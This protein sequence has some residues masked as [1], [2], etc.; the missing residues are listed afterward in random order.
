MTVQRTT[1]IALLLLVGLSGQPRAQET[2]VGETITTAE[3]TARSVE[4]AC[5]D[6]QVVGVCIWLTCTPYT[7][8]DID[9]SV[10]VFHYLPD[11]TVSS[12]ADSGENPWVDVAA[13]SQPVIELMDG[14]NNTEGSTVINETALRFKNV[15]VFGNPGIEAVSEALESTEYFCESEATMM[16]PYFLSVY[17]PF[18]REPLL[19]TP[20]ALLH[21]FTRVIGFGRAPLQSSTWGAVYPRIGFV[22]NAHD[23][24]AGAVAAQRAANIVTQRYQP[25]VY[26]PVVSEL[27]FVDDIANQGY[28]PPGEAVEG[29]ARTAKWQQLLPR[30]NA[31]PACHVFADLDDQL[32]AAIDVFAAR[33]NE[34][35]GYVWNL[36]RPYS[37]CEQKGA[38]L[39]AYN[40]AFTNTELSD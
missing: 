31:A 15:D 28:W 7:G 13:L 36:W 9:Y 4:M 12:Y 2:L 34:L 19:E 6:F 26:V 30:A 39:I 1:L 18:W 14:G 23:Y 33:T 40:P 27:P 37:C 5:V 17:D 38:V 25:H 20:L 21:F 3:I 11:V 35:T 32:G 22:H 16:F 8:C 10:Q 29:N 24:K